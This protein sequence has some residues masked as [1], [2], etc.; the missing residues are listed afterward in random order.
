[1]DMGLPQE[2]IQVM[3]D[4]MDFAMN[5]QKYQ[6]QMGGFEQYDFEAI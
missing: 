6:Q 5:P 2:D 3:M 1:M 4:Y